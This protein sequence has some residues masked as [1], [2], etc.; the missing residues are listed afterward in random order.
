MTMTMNSINAL[1]YRIKMSPWP[2][3]ALSS[4]RLFLVSVLSVLAFSTEWLP[5]R[6]DY[7]SLGSG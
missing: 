1:I 6:A 7:F 4:R 2:V 3:V 5:L